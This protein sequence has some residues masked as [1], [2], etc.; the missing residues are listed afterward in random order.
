M[1]SAFR[2]ED[3]AGGRKRHA[4]VASALDAPALVASEIAACSDVH[5]LRIS[6][7]IGRGAYHTCNLSIS[8][9]VPKDY[10]ALTLQCHR[11]KHRTNIH[12]DRTSLYLTSCRS[13]ALSL[14][15]CI[16]PSL[17]EQMADSKPDQDARSY[18]LATGYQGTA[19]SIHSHLL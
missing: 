13:N 1:L 6:L 16:S 5:R 11:L 4:E 10:I 15:D 2:A 3:A 9:L 17:V 8:H 14:Q 18:M 7:R 12:L 19:R